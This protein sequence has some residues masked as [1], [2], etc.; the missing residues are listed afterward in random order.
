MS[1]DDDPLYLV[2]AH[3]FSLLRGGFRKGRLDLEAGGQ[4]RGKGI[5]PSF[6]R[7]GSG[8]VLPILL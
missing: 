1:T 7:A 2:T 6:S 5:K 4:C 8:S 3:H